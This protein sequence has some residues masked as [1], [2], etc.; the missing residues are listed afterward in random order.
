MNIQ[1]Y[2][3]AEPVNANAIYKTGAC[4]VS[5]GKVALSA[6]PASHFSFRSTV[7]W[8]EANYESAVRRG[9][10]ETLT[11]AGY[12]DSSF[13]ANFVLHEID[14]HSIDSTEYGYFMAAKQATQQILDAAK[15]VRAG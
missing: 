6:S 15:I 14:W 7:V 4:R 8:P 1:A 5:Y 12:V 10:L 2:T 11:L 13:G 3:L 9:I